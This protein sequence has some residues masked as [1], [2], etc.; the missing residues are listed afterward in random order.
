[1]WV[2]EQADKMLYAELTLSQHQ[3]IRICFIPWPQ[4]QTHLIQKT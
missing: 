4:L 1:M 3:P 2:T